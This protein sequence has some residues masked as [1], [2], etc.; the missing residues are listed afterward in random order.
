[1]DKVVILAR[2]STD[3]QEYRRQ[4]NELKLFCQKMD[5]AI[6]EVAEANAKDIAGTFANK[7]SGAE[8]FENRTELRDMIEFVRSNDVKESY[9]SKSVVSVVT[10]SKL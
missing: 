5:W 9:A 10:P 2:V 7:V 6:D 4:I 8:S 1:M 3:R